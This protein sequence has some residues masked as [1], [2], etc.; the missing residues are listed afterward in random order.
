VGY[1]D[2]G[3][4]PGAIQIHLRFKQLKVFATT[5]EKELRSR[6]SPDRLSALLIFRVPFLAQ[7]LNLR[8]IWRDV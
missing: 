2:G 6:S 5:N 7:P 4:S 1:S 3:P 8:M